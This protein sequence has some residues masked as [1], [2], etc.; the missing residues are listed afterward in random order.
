M[1]VLVGTSLVAAF[2][3][4]VAALFAPCCITVLL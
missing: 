3:A 4:G 1:D 2:V